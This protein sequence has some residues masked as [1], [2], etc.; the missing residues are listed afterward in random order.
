MKFLE[1][2]YTKTDGSTSNRAVIELVTPTRFIEGI[3]VSQLPEAEF[4]IFT[5]AMSEMKRAQHEQTMELLETFDLKHNYRRFIPEQMAN[6]VT[7]YV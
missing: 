6:V 7:E 3:D 4:A 1:F 2:T 5:T